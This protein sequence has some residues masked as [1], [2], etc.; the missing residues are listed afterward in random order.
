M[1][2]SIGIRQVIHVVRGMQYR[3]QI[4]PSNYASSTLAG[5]LAD[6]WQW[7]HE[8]LRPSEH[9]P[10]SDGFAIRDFC[11]FVDKHAEHPGRISLV[12]SGPELVALCHEW[13][14]SLVQRHRSSSEMPRR[15]PAKVLGQIRQ[16]AER[17]LPVHALILTRAKAGSAFGFRGSGSPL[18]EYSKLEMKVFI[19]AA[20]RDIRKCEKRTSKYNLIADSGRDPEIHGWSLANVLWAI[21]NRKLVASVM[22]RAH[23]GDPT[24]LAVEIQDALRDCAADDFGSSTRAWVNIA[25]GLTTALYAVEDDLQ[26]FRILLLAASGMSTDEMASINVAD[27][28][29]SEEAV[30]VTVH[31]PRANRSRRLRFKA[32]NSSGSGWDFVSVLARLRVATSLTRAEASPELGQRLWIAHYVSNGKRYV[33]PAGFRKHRFSAWVQDRGLDVT[34]PLDTRR[35]RKSHKVARALKTGTIYGATGGEHTTRVFVN[36]YLP[37]VSLQVRAG[38]AITQAQDL[39]FTRAVEGPSVV[40]ESAAEVLSSRGA[41]D[42]QATEAAEEF[43]LATPV[44]A[45]LTIGSCRSMTNPPERISTGFCSEQV[46]RCLECPNAVIFKDHLPQLLIFGEWL[47][48]RQ[49]TTDPWQFHEHYGVIVANLNHAIALFTPGDIT[50]AQALVD[51]GQVQLHIPLSMKADLEP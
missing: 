23:G 50:T 24:R 46:R 51:S 44:D 35:F 47:R 30:F 9:G 20:R 48:E 21:R 38:Q 33:G 40:P 4:N 36:H 13:E 8:R 16:R 37:T 22:S 39:A 32:N 31:K 19:E 7:K 25:N 34:V 15:T 1:M 42:V 12:T 43:S 17:G 27:I 26:A 29:A 5:Q 14:Q 3:S 2:S 10:K 11:R 41:F 6:E 18:Q 49:K 45:G 28:E